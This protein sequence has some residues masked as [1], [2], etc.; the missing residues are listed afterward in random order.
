MAAVVTFSIAL[1]A[2]PLQ[3]AREG[4]IRILSDSPEAWSCASAI[5]DLRLVKT[6]GSAFAEWRWTCRDGIIIRCDRPSAEPID[7][8]SEMCGTPIS[9]SE[10]PARLATISWSANRP[11]MIQWRRL[12]AAGTSLIAE[13]Q[14]TGGTIVGV[15]RE[16][17]VVRFLRPDSAPVSHVLAPGLDSVNISL[18]EAMFGSELFGVGLSGVGRI[19]DVTY[20]G[21]RDGILPLDGPSST[22]RRGVFPG[23]YEFRLRYSS[24]LTSHAIP[25]RLTAGVTTEVTSELFASTGATH[26]QADPA[27][28]ELLPRR[29]ELFATTS[30]G[31]SV[32][33]RSI[34]RREFKNTELDWFIDGLAPGRYEATLS[35][36]DQ[37]LSGS[38]FDVSADVT[39][40]VTLA[41]PG[42]VLKL[43]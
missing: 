21:I 25:L 20:S 33:R 29:L 30:S 16:P 24:G 10:L 32:S 31:G 1:L 34:W 28:A 2:A 36:E 38:T 15:S 23:H 19:T 9:R 26:L 18:D 5:T 7:I 11:L 12:S 39:T 40:Q 17:R 4:F 37:P 3:Q 22:G 8:P 42:G 43:L 41:A 6:F 13:R 35:G 27:M 14:F